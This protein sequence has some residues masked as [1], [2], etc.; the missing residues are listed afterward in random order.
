MCVRGQIC[1]GGDV[2]QGWC[3]IGDVSSMMVP[4]SSR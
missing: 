2:C 1:E 4:L 3:V